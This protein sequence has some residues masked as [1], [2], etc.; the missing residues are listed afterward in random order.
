GVKVQGVVT[1][2]S[3]GEAMLTILDVHLSGSEVFQIT[4]M[5]AKHMPPSSSDV[6]Q[7]EAAPTVLGPAMT[8]LV[9]SADDATHPELHI[10]VRLTGVPD[11]PGDDGNVC[12]TDTFDQAANA[13][14]H[15]FADGTGCSPADKC[16]INAV[17]SEG[18]CLGSAK[19]CDDQSTCT[20]DYC[21]Q[22]TGE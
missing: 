8:D 4:K 21:N 20:R 9:I 14:A 7:I 17:C 19:T 3:K 6:L 2:S 13:C 18:V 1:V 12:T 10:P 11:P 22:A 16:I 15:S 5:P